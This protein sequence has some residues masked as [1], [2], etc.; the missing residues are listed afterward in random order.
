M[1]ILPD[2]PEAICCLVASAQH[3]GQS[4]S[5]SMHKAATCVYIVYLSID[6]SLLSSTRQPRTAALSLGSALP[7]C[8][9]IG[10]S[11]LLQEQT[12]SAE[13]ASLQAQLTT[14]ASSSQ[15][16]QGTNTALTSQLSAAQA[17]VKQL[18]QQMTLLQQQAQRDRSDSAAVMDLELQQKESAWRKAKNDAVATA[19]ADQAAR[20]EALR[21]R[22]HAE[23]TIAAQREREN[24]NQDSS[25]AMAQQEAAQQLQL[26]ALREQHTEALSRQ[27]AEFESQIAQHAQQA[28]AKSHNALAADAA[29]LQEAHAEDLQKLAEESAQQLE[30]CKQK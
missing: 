26:A 24:L 5:F 10:A 30:D 9:C 14:V 8:K 1:W 15:S 4:Q 13:L 16:M 28:A 6:T 12:S 29:R 20:N 19:L 18:Q 21:E 23:L 2:L 7:L 3:L 22:L 17:E 11:S 27:A 25:A